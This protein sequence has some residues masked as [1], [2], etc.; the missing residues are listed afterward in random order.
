VTREL[1]VASFDLRATGA[2]VQAVIASL[3]AVRD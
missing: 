1:A 2:D 3:D